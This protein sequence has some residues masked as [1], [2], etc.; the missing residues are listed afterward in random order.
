MFTVF[1]TQMIRTLSLPI[2]VRYCAVA[3]TLL[4]AII[5]NPSFAADKSYQVNKG[6]KLKITVWKEEGLNAEVMVLPDG[7]ITFPIVGVI[8]VAGKTLEELQVLLRKRLEAYIPGPEV[9]VSLL[10]LEGNVIYIIGEVSRPGPY[11]MTKS[12]KV[13]QALIDIRI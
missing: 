4:F 6:D 5:A 10:T 7:T 1:R 3:L 8:S 9:N 2:D 12:L 13:M 11:V